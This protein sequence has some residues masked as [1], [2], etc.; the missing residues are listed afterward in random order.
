ME[1]LSVISLAVKQMD[2]DYFQNFPYCTRVYVRRQGEHREVIGGALLAERTRLHKS[3]R[4][5]MMLPRS[6]CQ[7]FED[8]DG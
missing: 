5:S 7:A 4:G 8:I 2:T 3:A 1:P 6:T